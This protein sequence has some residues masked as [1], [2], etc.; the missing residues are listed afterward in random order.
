M[1]N[2]PTVSTTYSTQRPG[3]NCQLLLRF[4]TVPH[5]GK[6]YVELDAYVDAGIASRHTNSALINN[7]R[8]PYLLLTEQNDLLGLEKSC[9]VLFWNR[10]RRADLG[11]GDKRYQ[12]GTAFRREPLQDTVPGVERGPAALEC[13]VP[14]PGVQRIILFFS[15]QRVKLHHAVLALAIEL[16]Q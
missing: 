11:R 10:E 16:L 3:P 9:E 4:T 15:E 6:L 1:S 5:D 2:C 8:I 14:Q 7:R 13:D 12:G